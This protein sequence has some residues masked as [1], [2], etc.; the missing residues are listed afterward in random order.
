MREAFKVSINKVQ[1]AELAELTD[2]NHHTESMRKLCVWVLVA[3]R[4]HPKKEMMA[5]I[6]EEA[7]VRHDLMCTI[8]KLHNKY[9]HLPDTCYRLRYD[10]MN[11]TLACVKNEDEVRGCL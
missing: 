8:E 2:Q 4:T 9:N 1:M 5:H 10:L 7:E 3:L 6:I 11:K